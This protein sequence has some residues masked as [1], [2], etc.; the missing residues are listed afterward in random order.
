MRLTLRTLLAYR[1][2]VLDP[3]DAAILE[4]KIRDS[5][6]AK[7]IS[8]RIEEGMRNRKL[9]PIPVDAREF[10]FEANQVAEFLD[11]TIPMETLP[12]MERKCL[13]NSTLL[14]E[15]GSCHQILSRALSAP[16][17]I[18]SSLRQRIR[19]LPSQHPTYSSSLGGAL[20][21][22]ARVLRLDPANPSNGKTA[23]PSD[24]SDSA[25]SSQVKPRV[26]LR[27]SGI[28]LNDGL[29]RLVPE[30]LIGNDRRWMKHV[31]MAA[32]LLIALIVVGAIAIG[33]LDRVRNLLRKPQGDEIA[34]NKVESSRPAAGET[35]N[36]S[37]SLSHAAETSKPDE[38]SVNDSSIAESS[39][40]PPPPPSGAVK[41]SE[42]PPMMAPTTVLPTTVL[43]TTVLPTTVLP[44]TVPS[45][46]LRMQWLPD[47]KTSSESIVF[48]K[49]ISASD[50]LSHW[51]RLNA[52]E[53]VQAGERV[54]V[55]PAQRTEIRIEPGIRWLCAGEIDFEL[56]P[57]TKTAK[58]AMKTG[59][60]LLFA[61][62]DAN[63][64]DVDCNGI[65]I[66]IRFATSDACCAL[67]LQ[68]ALIPCS[69]EML[70]AGKLDIQ[71]S[72]RL[73]GIQGSL[74]FHS[75]GSNKGRGQG[76]L[77]VGQYVDWI[78]GTLKEKQELVE[79][80]NWL[81]STERAIDQIAATDL[82]RA[83]A[84]IETREIDSELLKLITTGQGQGRGPAAAALAS[85]TR[86]MIGKY[87]HIFSA[88][89][90]LNRK[91]LHNFWQSL[92]SQIPQS[93]GREEYRSQL[94]A[95]IRADS[96][97]RANSIL[98]LLTPKSQ[99][100]LSAGA[101]KLLI[102]ALSSSAMDER[103]LAINQLSTI[104]GKNLGY[105]PDKNSVDAIQQWRK[106][107]GKGEIRY[108]QSNTPATEPN[109]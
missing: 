91:G 9:A 27:G 51:K 3:K 49:T 22:H 30:Y 54:V 48:A 13:E 61:T 45:K 19:D 105:H 43:P 31:G 39:L 5:S 93:L 33:P 86:M 89:G 85:R 75:I 94:V 102:E 64:I 7:M 79:T 34:Q 73:T 109:R 90:I 100:Q 26:D 18:P 72:V 92:L 20:E 96:P 12:D 2:G 107:L 60:S 35:S 106:V 29:G 42:T 62:P 17:A 69:D 78:Q 44:S 87:D 80:P 50:G 11:D 10:G 58:V 47:S 101:D 82:Q 40:G 74:E 95:S 16:A 46:P 28:E 21:K 65:L 8:Q 83:L 37:G 24:A 53:Y 108:P 38:S 71:S 57:S 88:E 63:S 66:S 59:R 55:A 76:T 68:N 14:S 56:L 97:N 81:H 15:I 103:I 70:Q 32:C 77:T 1:D 36:S 25:T 98:S 4:A 67:E 84:G 23:N 41:T 99:E 104:T 52:G 6:T